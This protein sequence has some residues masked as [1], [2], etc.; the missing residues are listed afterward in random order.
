M[1][2]QRLKRS[3]LFRLAPY[4][5]DDVTYIKWRWKAYM[6]YPLNLEDPKTFNEKLQ[7]IKLH[8]RQPIY[9]KLVDKYEVKQYVADIIGEEHIIP[10]IG[11]YDRVEDIDFEALPQQFVLKCTHDSGG[12]VIC[13]DK[14]LLDHDAAIRKLQHGLKKNYYYQNREW[15][16]KNVKPRI[17]AEQYMDNDGQELD[18]Y[19]VHNFN[20]EPKVV[21]V[22]SDRYKKSGLAEDFYSCEWEHL[23]ISR[24]GLRHSAEVQEKP[25]ELDEMLDLAKKLSVGIPFVRTDFYIINHQVYFGE[26]TFFPAC[27]MKPFVPRE[28][29]YKFGSYIMLPK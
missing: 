9:S 1:N 14:S 15:P 3:L 18:D 11:V 10:T 24:P 7:W 2:Y 23:D 28:W 13:K 29:D 16:Y 27:G 21:L 5:K 19:K 26:M 6:D 12:I 8:D 20:G 17:I 4:I 25:A 22:C